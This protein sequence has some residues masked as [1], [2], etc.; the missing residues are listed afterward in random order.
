MV[1]AGRHKTSELL[2]LRYNSFMLRFIDK[3]SAKPLNGLWDTVIAQKEQIDAIDT[4]QKSVSV[5]VKSDVPVGIGFLGDLHIGSEGVDYERLR[6][7]I[8]TIL[9]T[10]NL[11]VVCTGDEY[12]NYTESSPR[13]GK[14]ESII[15]PELQKE[16]ATDIAVKLNGKII[17]CIFGCH[18][19]WSRK[20]D[21]FNWAKYMANK[22]GSANL[23]YGGRIYVELGKQTYVIDVRHRYI[24]NSSLNLS[25]TFKRFVAMNGK[26]AADIV[27]FGHYHTPFVAQEYMREKLITFVRNGSYKIND[28]YAKQ[29]GGWY[30]IPGIPVCVLHP[31]KFMVE[32]FQDFSSAVA[33]LSRFKNSKKNHG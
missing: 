22:A 25:N 7:D 13:G 20:S 17:S 14:F 27:A 32:P 3:K 28:R 24:Y 31:E 26:E 2:E 16:L 5:N 30:G 33:Y 12:D 18:P 6:N 23:G 10:P 4:E 9:A 8:N 15:Q 1:L 19:S 21:D 11:Y 29:L